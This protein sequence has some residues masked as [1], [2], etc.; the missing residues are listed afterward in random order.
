LRPQRHPLQIRLGSLFVRILKSL[1]TLTPLSQLVGFDQLVSFLASFTDDLGLYGNVF[2]RGEV[3]Y[4]LSKYHSESTNSH[5]L[6]DYILTKVIR[7]VFAK[8][9]SSITASGRRAISS[10]TDSFGQFSTDMLPK[11]WSHEKR[12]V[13]TLLKWTVNQ[14]TV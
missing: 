12:Y 11:P 6:V 14:L 9:P 13:L 5:V 7:P 4:L 1:D 10:D 3:L 2:A 8:I